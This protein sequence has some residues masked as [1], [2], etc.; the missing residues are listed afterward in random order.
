MKYCRKCVQP[1]TRPGVLFDEEGVC[2]A[3]RY[4]ERKAEV[5]WEKREEEILKIA[6]QAR[7]RR[8]DTPYDCVVGV[9]GGKDS[10]F[11]AYYAR[12]RLGLRPLLVNALPDKLTDVGRHNLE[13]MVSAGFDIIHMRPNPKVVKKLVK[14]FFYD[15]CNPVKPNEYPIC[16]AAPLIADKFNIPLILQ[17]ENAALTLGAAAT[18]QSLDDDAFSMVNLDTLAGGD[19]SEFVGDGVGM[20]DLF[21]YKFPDVDSMKRKG[22]RAVFIQ[23]YA[24]EWSQ[25]RNA[26]FSVARGLWGRTTENLYD[27]GRYRRYTALDCDMVIMN[28]M[29]KYLKFGFGFATD[30]ACYDIR[31]GRLTRNEAIWLVKEYDGMCAE[32]YIQS[33]CEY[34]AISVEEFWRVVDG[35]VNKKLFRKEGGRW[36]PKFEPGVDFDEE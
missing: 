35:H 28:Q 29:L 26:E 2:F 20:D 19:L 1:D 16:V 18:G 34:I 36:V 14:H 10:T 5:D 21:L 7:E 12:D 33:F 17:G 23:Y 9:S 8:G 27:I 31:E 30:E 15:R 3:C 6:Q 24:K 22:I 32:R 11:Q 25:V 13:N 4:E